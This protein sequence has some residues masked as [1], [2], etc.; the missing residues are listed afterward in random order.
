MMSKK[1]EKFDLVLG[2]PSF[3]EADNIAHVARQLAI[4]AKRYFPD[5]STVII[6]LDN[7]SPDNTKDA[8][9]NSDTE[10]VPKRY[11]STE[12]G[13]VGKGNNLRNLFTEVERLQPKAAVM[14]DADLKSITPEWIKH[15]GEPLFNGYS[16]VAPL[17]IRHKYDGTITNGIA[18]PMTRA[19]YG[20]RIRQ[21][22]GGDFGFSGKLGKAYVNGNGWNEAIANFGID[23]WMTTLAI[24]QRAQVCQAFLGRPK[25]H[26]TKDPGAHLGPMFREVVGTMFSLMKNFDSFWG[27]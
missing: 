7:N 5:L 11:I 9:L 6:N 3:N 4:G 24:N 18:Y 23:I 15:L 12:K 27:F 8:F 19:L 20:R 22:I 1:A 10:D 14:V 2:I 13:V 17:Y 26:R 21:P 25:I 16:Y